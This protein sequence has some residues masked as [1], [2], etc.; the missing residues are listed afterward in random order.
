MLVCEPVLDTPPAPAQ[1]RWSLSPR[2]EQVAPARTQIKEQATPT[3]HAG[4]L[5]APAHAFWNA[6]R[7]VSMIVGVMAVGAAI[8]SAAVLNGSLILLGF[9]VAL[10]MMCFIGLPLILA[11]I[12]DATKA[13]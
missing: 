10:C 6:F 2:E 12:A 1:S 7:L 13:H 3:A 8:V 5:E 4:E 11:S 9:C